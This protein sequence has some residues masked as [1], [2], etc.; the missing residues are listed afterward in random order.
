VGTLTGFG[1]AT[2]RAVLAVALTA[3]LLAACGG[4]DDSAGAAQISVSDAF[5]LATVTGQPN[6]AVYFTIMATGA[7]MLEQVDVPDSIAD[8]AEMHETIT[9]ANGA[10]SMQEMTSGVEL[11]PGTAVTFTPGGKHVMLVALVQPLTTGQ[12]FDVT[13]EFANADPITLPVAVVESAP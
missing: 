6:G 12:T 8:H 1:R 5:A 7:D 3:G 2:T 9:A 11:D 13:L 4:D 10:M